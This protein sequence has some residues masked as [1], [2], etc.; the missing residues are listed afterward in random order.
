MDAFWLQPLNETQLV[1]L[2]GGQ[3]RLMEKNFLN[4]RLPRSQ[5][6]VPRLEA[7]GPGSGPGARLKHH[8]E[9]VLDSI[10]VQG[11]L[12]MQMQL[13][14]KPQPLHQSD[15]P[16]PLPS[17]PPGPP[18]YLLDTCSPP[19]PQCWESQRHFGAWVQLS[20]REEVPSTRCLVSLSGT[21]ELLRQC[22]A[23]ILP[24]AEP[25]LGRT[26]GGAA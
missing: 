14:D 8:F 15:A 16:K 17:G 4:S 23:Q 21:S 10:T 25:H 6:S 19:Y 7:A 22:R 18:W 11:H 9:V 20:H 24:R 1:Q 13:S 2:Q 5:R 3:L 12:Q 26:W